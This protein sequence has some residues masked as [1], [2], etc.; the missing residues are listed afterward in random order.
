MPEYEGELSPVPAPD[1][2]VIADM[3]VAILTGMESIQKAKAQ[4]KPVV[5]CSVLTP[6][7]ILHAMGVAVI[8]GELLGGYASIFGL[9]GK[10]CQFA[11]RNGL[12]RDVCAV[13]RC[14]VGM[15]VCEQ[16]ERDEFF[17]NA[18]VPPDLVIGS[19]F[20]CM[21]E[22]KSFLQ[23]VRKYDIPYYFIDAPINTWGPEIP[24]H[25]VAY[26]AA[27]FQGLIDFL[28]QHG[29]AFD[30]QRLKEEVAFTKS[31]NAILGE[32]EGY[33][34]AVPSPM[35][36]YDTIIATT[37]P[38][39]LPEEM[40]NLELF[41]KLRDQ[42]KERVE[43]GIG[44]VENERL[45]LLWLGIP[46]LC[47]FHLLNYPEKH[48]AVVAKSMLEFLTGFTLDPEL[49]DP[50]APLES[51]A[52]AQLASP[53]NPLIQGSIDY[54][55]QAVRDYRIDGV[56]AVV[57]RTCGLIPGTLRLT[58]EALSR[59]TGVP[60]VVFD[61]DGVDQREYDREAAK[62]HIDSFIE[63]LLARKGN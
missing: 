43:R 1:L 20:P 16:E 39:A 14:S 30:P 48:Q 9:S 38:L 50:Q 3:Q 12:S 29:Y 35:K 58:K 55:L 59:A 22:S 32:I 13:H 17:N 26:Y 11:E 37:T 54:F 41:E 52:R 61:L 8:Y 4:G 47:D 7:E 49:I 45:R 63:T 28:V 18:F 24:E 23:V 40:R 21:S 46:P 56:I 34:R 60:S 57:K 62:A 33:R 36:A 15:A 5:W 10:Y 6:K 2:E 42:L 53:A 44:V 19:N 27:Q 51:L 25:A 31:L